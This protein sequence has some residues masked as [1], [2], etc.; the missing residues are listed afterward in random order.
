MTGAPDDDEI[1][2]AVG[3]RQPPVATQ[4]KKGQ[5]GNPKG[6]PKRKLTLLEALEVVLDGRVT[7]MQNGK[8]VTKTKREIAAHTLANAIAKGDPKAIATYLALMRVAG[9]NPAAEGEDNHN[10]DDAKLVIDAFM[11]RLN[12]AIHDEE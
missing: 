5:S 11:R 6:R 2:P 3:Y 7:V 4:F 8:R 9:P 12:G 10:I 1:A